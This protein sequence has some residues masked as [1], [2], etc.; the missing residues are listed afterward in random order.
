MFTLYTL[1]DN[2]RIDPK[3]LG[4][5]TEQAIAHVLSQTFIDRVIQDVGLIVTLYDILKVGEGAV[6]HSDGGAH[7][8][9]TFR[10]VVFKP[11]PGEMLI[12]NVKDMSE[13]GIKVSL[14]F[15]DDVTIPAEMLQQPAQWHEAGREWSWAMEEE[16]PPLYYTRGGEIRIKTHGI[17]FYAVPSLAKQAEQRAAGEAVEGSAALPHAPMVVVGRADSTG[18]GMIGWA[19]G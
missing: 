7:Y 9:V 6:Y 10:V 16:E 5:P 13:K 14:G 3:H 11:F 1:E 4:K 2:V 12:G 15:F 19:W 8:K 18:L 17:K